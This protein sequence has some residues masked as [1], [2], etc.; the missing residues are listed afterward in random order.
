MLSQGTLL[1]VITIEY[2]CVTNF[3]FS[4]QSK[5]PTTKALGDL[6]PGTAVTAELWAAPKSRGPPPGLSAKSGSLIN[7]WTSNLGSTSAAWGA[8]R[9]S[10]NWG[11]SS[12][13]LLRNLTAQVFLLNVEID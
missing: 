9:S 5:L 4:P 1:I 8:Q 10:G 13:L 12:W 2:R 7:G 3:N 11:S 6:N